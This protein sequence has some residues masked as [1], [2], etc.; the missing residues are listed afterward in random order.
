MRHHLT[1]PEPN[2][3]NEFLFKF[4]L[5]GLD[6]IDRMLVDVAS[7]D[8]IFHKAKELSLEGQEQVV[9]RLLF[10]GRIGSEG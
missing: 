1:H 5:L 6:E 9:L 8:T 4:R 10:L 2:I 3:L 7:D